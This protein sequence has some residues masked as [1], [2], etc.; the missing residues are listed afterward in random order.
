MGREKERDV[1][2]GNAYVQNIY[3]IYVFLFFFPPNDSQTNDGA[4][5]L[6][7]RQTVGLRVATCQQMMMFLLLL[8]Q[9]W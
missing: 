3:M 6:V 9:L 8:W 4:T 2:C 1:C 5:S 7:G